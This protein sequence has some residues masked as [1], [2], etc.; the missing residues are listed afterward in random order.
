MKRKSWTVETPDGTTFKRSS[1]G[2][3]YTHAVIALRNPETL[4][5]RSGWELLGWAGSPEL[6]KAR[7]T[8]ARNAF[9]G[10]YWEN[11]RG[12]KTMQFIAA[13]NEARKSSL[14]RKPTYLEVVI[15]EAKPA[16]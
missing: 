6:A 8:T 14:Y 15:L 16:K 2:R 7:A 12:Y 11:R 10:D 5:G 1:E 9:W 3:I 4:E 13:R